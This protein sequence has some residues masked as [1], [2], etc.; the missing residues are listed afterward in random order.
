[1]AIKKH[2]SIILP[3]YN[4]KENLPRLIDEIEKSIL[5]ENSELIVVDDNSPDGTYKLVEDIQKGRDNIKLIVRKNERGLAS[6]IRR[7]IEESSY[8]TIIIMD[9]DLSHDSHTLPKMLEKSEDYDMVVASRFVNEGKMVAPWYRV[10]GSYLMNLA[11]KILLNSKIHDNTGGFLLLNKKRL[12]LLDLDS[13][14]Y[15]YGDY[16]IRLLYK[17]Q[18]KGLKIYELG[19]VHKYR[20]KGESKTSFFNMAFKYFWEI[21]KLKK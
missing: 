19:Y 9:T 8:D 3:T 21:L 1:M 14:F 5:K 4:E 13:I 16:C 15:G 6:A 17:A 2:F 11:V 7:G 10:K 12:S 18:K 20:I